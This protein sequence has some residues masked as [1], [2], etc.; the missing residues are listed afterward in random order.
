MTF[1]ARF[2]LRRLIAVAIAI[3]GLGLC[4]SANADQKAGLHVQEVFAESAST[5]GFY[6]AESVSADCKFGVFYLDLSTPSGRAQLALLMQAKAQGLVLPRID[7]IK[8]SDGTCTAT[9]LH[10]I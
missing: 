4:S 9:G 5:G 1:G 3:V 2:H 10:I 7:Y 8:N 6:P